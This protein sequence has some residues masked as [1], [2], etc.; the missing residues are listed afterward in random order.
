MLCK[1]GVNDFAPG[2][3]G[4]RNHSKRNWKQDT[5]VSKE[6]R[7][8]LHDFVS[9]IADQADVVLLLCGGCIETY[10]YVPHI[11]TRWDKCI[12]ELNFEIMTD[13]GVPAS[14][15]KE[16][17]SELDMCSS[18]TRNDCWH[19]VATEHSAG[20]TGEMMTLM[21]KLCRVYAP[22]K[23][24]TQY[25]DGILALIDQPTAD[26]TSVV[27]LDGD[28]SGSEEVVAPPGA[29]PVASAEPTTV[30]EE[31]KEEPEEPEPSLGG[32]PEQEREDERQDRPC[33][34]GGPREGGA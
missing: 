8:A 13:F 26:L 25:I 19:P 15:G 7:Q 17:V 10:A 1:L 14:R 31:I 32:S 9:V 23:A 34:L 24:L 21:L 33:R 5:E 22:C 12:Q 27:D 6:C 3:T 30:K 18:V 11:A 29:G 4:Y 28:S 16:F 20:Q 2:C